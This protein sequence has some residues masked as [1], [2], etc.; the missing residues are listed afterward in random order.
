M[1]THAIYAIHFATEAIIFFPCRIVSCSL[2]GLILSVPNVV[3][4][5]CIFALHSPVFSL[6]SL[7]VHTAT[8]DLKLAH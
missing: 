5:N 1:T 7:V 2:I 6:F 4:P 8:A 3:S